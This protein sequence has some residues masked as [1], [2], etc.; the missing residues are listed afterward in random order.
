LIFGLS[1]FRRGGELA[2]VDPGLAI[3]I[4]S[5][6]GNEK[7]RGILERQAKS[8]WKVSGRDVAYEVPTVKNGSL[9]IT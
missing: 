2:K 6:K 8:D 7:G 4:R 5:D 1:L 3:S 9:K